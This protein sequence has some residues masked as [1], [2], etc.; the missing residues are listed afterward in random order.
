[1][2]FTHKNTIWD[3]CWV[4]LLLGT[5]HEVVEADI[6]VSGESQERGRLGPRQGEHVVSIWAQNCWV[7]NWNRMAYGARQEA[8]PRNGIWGMMRRWGQ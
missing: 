8:G 2:S 4:G 5:K 6:L 3:I 1:M 7:W